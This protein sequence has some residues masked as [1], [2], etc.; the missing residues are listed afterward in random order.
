M[1]PRAPDP[2]SRFALAALLALVAFAAQGGDADPTFVHRGDGP[3][4]AVPAASPVQFISIDRQYV[5][6]FA[7]RFVVS[8]TY[9]YGRGSAPKILSHGGEGPLLAF[10]PDDDT[11]TT[12]PFW[13][14]D[15]PVKQ[16]AIANRNAFVEAVIPPEVLRAVRSGELPMTSGHVSFLASDYEAWVECAQA[17]YA[18]TFVAMTARQDV[19]LAQ[20]LPQAPGC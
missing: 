2:S 8:G 15:A 3:S 11:R 4:F 7:G 5:A 6:H 9:F 12:L 10:A 18:T 20:A 16:L 1:H 14:D 19:Q 17:T 13:R